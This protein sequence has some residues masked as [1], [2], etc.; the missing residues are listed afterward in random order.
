MMT[1]NMN[2]FCLAS[3]ILFTL[4]LPACKRGSSGSQASGRI[5][6]DNN[7][8]RL[9]T[10]VTYY[11][12]EE[13]GDPDVFYH[14]AYNDKGFKLTLK[15][16]VEPPTIDGVA[17]EASHVTISGKYAYV[18]YNTVGKVHQGGV[19]IFDEVQAGFCRTGKWWGY[20]VMDTVPDIVAMGKPMGAGYPLSGVGARADIADVFHTQSFSIYPAPI[21]QF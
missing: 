8:E 6:V 15:A 5:L 7:E 10:R 21:L 9:N 4:V 17:L 18:S 14:A 3:L 19:V 2:K 11:N 20:E 1:C 16:K 13:P 12:E